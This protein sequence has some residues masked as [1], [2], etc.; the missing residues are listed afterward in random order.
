MLIPLWTR[1]DAKVVRQVL[2]GRRNDFGVLVRRYLPTVLAVAHGHLGNPA[3]AEDVAQESFLAAYQRLNT[4]REPHKFPSWLLAIARNTAVSWQRHQK[5]EVPLDEGILSLSLPQEPPALE[6]REMQELLHKTLME[7]EP[8]TREILMLH[9]YAGHSLREIA[10]MQGITRLAAAKRLQRARESLGAAFLKQIPEAPAR[11]VLKKH[12]KKITAAVLAAGT[13]WK[14]APAYGMVAGL[15]IGAAKLAVGASIILLLL[16]GAFFSAPS[17]LGWEP[18]F[19]EAAQ[20]EVQPVASPLVLPEPS[21]TVVEEPVEVAVPEESGHYSISNVLVTPFDQVIGNARVVAERVTWKPEELPPAKTEKWVVTANENGIF[22]FED[23]PSGAYS[24]TAQTRLLGGAHDFLITKEG[25]VRGPRN[26]KMYPFLRSYGVV[27]DSAGNPVAGAVLYPVSHELFPE[28]EFDH[29][30]VAGIRACTDAEGRFRFEGIIPGAWKIFVVAPGHVP[31]YTDY[32]P[33]YGLRTT[34]VIEKPGSMILRVADTSGKV[35]AGV[36]GQIVSGKSV[37]TYDNYQPKHRVQQS[38]VSGEDGVFRIDP[39]ASGEYAFSIEDAMLT[40]ANLNQSV[41]VKPGA[42]AQVDLIVTQGAMILGRVINSASGEGIAGITVNAYLRQRNVLV[43]RE[44]LTGPDGAYALTGL[45]GGE[46]EVMARKAPKGDFMNKRLTVSVKAGETVEHQDFAVEPL[47]TLAGRVVNADGSP[48]AA[49]V[50]LRGGQYAETQSGVDGSFSFPVTLE[51]SVTICAST[52]SM[53]SLP[54][55]V[56]LSAEQTQELVLEL[57][58]VASGGIEGFVYEEDG[59][60]AYG[61]IVSEQYLNSGQ[62]WSE[63]SEETTPDGRFLLTGLS[64][65]EYQLHARRRGGYG[66]SFMPVTVAVADGAITQNV[67]IRPEPAGDLSIEGTVYYPSGLRCP[68]AVLSLGETQGTATGPLGNFTFNNLREGSYTVFAMSPGYSPA[69]VSGVAAGTSDLQVVLESYCQLSGTVLD[70][71]TH[72]PVQEF[73]VAYTGM[74]NVSFQH[75]VLRNNEGSFSDPQ[76]KFHFDKVPALPLVLHVRAAGYVP[77][78]QALD[79]AEGGEEI[80]VAVELS[81]AARVTGTIRNEAGEPVPFARIRVPDTRQQLATESDTAGN[82][83]LEELSAGRET[84]LI[85]SSDAYASVCVTA[86]PGST[87]PLDIVM[88][89]GG[90]VRVR[91]LLNGQPSPKFFVKVQGADALPKLAL[92]PSEEAVIR[93]VAAGEVEVTVQVQNGDTIAEQTASAT[94]L[95]GQ[96]T[97]VDVDVQTNP[98]TVSGGES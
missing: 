93:G 92:E 40:L 21:A 26:V 75:E 89:Q 19:S 85:V 42:E 25:K 43:Q 65:G 62:H 10:A 71:V 32:I 15:V 50:T 7:L 53:K 81:P 61:V 34:I 60:P 12:A 66:A 2:A 57:T 24:I 20:V 67:E 69:I 36:K 9:Y 4:L 76:G 39:I 59:K 80:T 77:W 83:T 68:F 8:D 30:T 86:I 95:R 70:A 16:G 3:D 31:F 56:D 27:Q 35:I 49:E 38:F 88:Q 54:V 87:G 48:A 18:N 14:T 98:E 47:A 6:R 91:A 58:V 1:S 41:R 29:V 94:V 64:A 63:S 55:K 82:F 45:P 51:G 72:Q 97:C 5:N 90:S 46:Y 78:Q 73:Q 11:Q 79:D 28:Q 13:V 44:V 33:F 52:S 37:S 96:E 74:I 17:L 22:I 84:K 23:L